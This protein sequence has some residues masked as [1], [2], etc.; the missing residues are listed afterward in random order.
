MLDR[1]QEGAHGICVKRCGVATQRPLKREVEITRRG[2][3]IF[4]MAGLSPYLCGRNRK[5]EQLPGGRSG[6]LAA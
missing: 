3:D 6:T 4:D 5:T 2:Q 1:G